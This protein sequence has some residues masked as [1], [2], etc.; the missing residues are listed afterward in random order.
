VTS[1]TDWIIENRQWV[2][3]GI[4]VAVIVG[5]YKFVSRLLSRNQQQPTQTPLLDHSQN[6]KATAIAGRDVH[7]TYGH[8]TNTTATNVTPPSSPVVPVTP[9]TPVRA[10]VDEYRSKPTPADLVAAIAALPHLQQVSARRHYAG[11]KVRW[12]LKINKVLERPK[13][14]AALF[15]NYGEELGPMVGAIVLVSDYVWLKNVRGNEK[16]TITGTYVKSDPITIYVQ[17][18]SMELIEPD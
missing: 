4:G 13:G 3:S 11:I 12:E 5:G 7:I 1:P 18:N 16:V 10:I 14:Y 6:A 17:I 2:F 9:V 15:F 8:L